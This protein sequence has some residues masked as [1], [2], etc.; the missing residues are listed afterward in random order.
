M[1]EPHD[2]TG[3]ELASEIAR[4]TVEAS[5]YGVVLPEP[6]APRTPRRT[7]RVFEQE[8]SGAHPD[9]RD[10][11]LVGDVLNEVVRKR[12]WKPRI[13]LSTVLRRWPELV[14]ESNAAH[15]KPVNYDAGVLIVDCDSTA[16]ATAMRYAASQLVAKLNAAL[17]EQTVLRV[18]FRGP[19]APSWKKGLRSVQGRGPRDTYG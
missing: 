6:A 11:K 18:E 2:P 3:L 16:W 19:K 5:E 4:A 14:G 12:G 1:S 13:N 8:R 9:D 15:S 17:G 7:R 10:P